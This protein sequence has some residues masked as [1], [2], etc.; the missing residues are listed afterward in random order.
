MTDS[1]KI[2]ENGL[3]FTGDKQNRAGQMTLLIQNGRIGEI[4]RRAEVLKMMYPNAEVIDATSKVLI[5][6]FVDAH[7]TGESFILRYLTSN[8]PMSRWNKNPVIQRTFDY[9]RTEATY[10]EFLMLYRL[11]YY[12]ALK[13]GVTTLAEYGIDTPEHSLAAALE[14]IRQTNVRGF[15][16]LHNGDQIEAARMLREKSIR[17]AFV[18]ADEENLTTYNLQSTIRSANELQWPIIL[19]LG[20]TRR[21]YDVVKKNFNKSIA[22]LYAEYRVFDSPVQLLHLACFEEGDIE[23]VAKSGVPLVYSPMAILQKGTESPPYEKLLKQKI[24]LALSSDWGA[25]HPLENIQ[26]YCSILKT[27]DLPIERAYDLLALHTKNGAYALGLDAEIGSIET[28]KKADIVFLD[29]SDFRINSVFADE[30]TEGI[31]NTVLQEVTSQQVSEV[32]INGEFYVREGNIL[33]YSEDDLANEGKTLLNKLLLISG[34]KSLAASSSATILQFPAEPNNEGQSKL[35]DLPFEEGFRIVRKNSIPSALQE[36]KE[37]SQDTL[38]ELPKN[39]RKIF[40]D[41]DE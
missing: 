21:A 30:N 40:G 20:Q 39:V 37:I 17:F 25:A 2:I 36:K 6:G 23:I 35:N 12:A 16:G 29:L 5:P 27:L 32:M 38:R 31:L 10:E 15:I 8:Q 19:H 3:V 34:Q 18:I 11:S 24:K 28:G 41:D 4:G 14:A 33:T 13:S 1:I 26:T 22:Q 9:L 7:H